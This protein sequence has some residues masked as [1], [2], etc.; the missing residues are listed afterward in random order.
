MASD[1]TSEKGQKLS[2]A[3][4]KSLAAMSPRQR[5][6]YFTLV[7]IKAFSGFLDI[8]G[9]VLIGLLAG[10]AAN[11]LDPSKPLVIFGIELPAV[12]QETLVALVLIV[13][14]VFVFKAVVAIAFGKAITVFAARVESQMAARIAG[15]LFSG[16]LSNLQR[17]SKGEVVWAVMGST[18]FAFGGL[19][20][21]LSIFVSEGLLLILVLA[22]FFLVDPLATLFVIVYFAII[23]AIIQIA[24]SRALRKSGID[25]A[26]GNM[27]SL[28]VVDDTVG[29]YREITVFNRQSFFV[30]K[31]YAVRYR[32]SASMGMMA[33]LGGMPRYIVETALM[34]GVVMF[35]GVQ[36][37][38]GQLASGLVIV[39]VFLT[40]GV[41]IMASLLP[42]Q[43]AASAAKSQAEQSMLAHQ[44]LGEISATSV[45]VTPDAVTPVA[46]K[47]PAPARKTTHRAAS[48]LS[49]ALKK[50][51]FRYPGSTTLALKKISL[52]IEPGQHVAFI[53]PSGAGK[54][55]LVDLILG[56]LEPTAGTVAIG[57]QLLAGRELL[58]ENLVAYVPQSPGMVSGTIA[59]NVAIGTPLDEI[60]IERVIEALRSAHL[61]EF[62]D[63][64]PEGIFTPVGSQGNSLSGGQI[65]RLGLARALY[66]K[67]KLIILDEA[68]S[69][70]DASAE[71]F[72]SQSLKE[73]GKDVTVIVIAHRLS[74]VQHSDVVFVVD[75]GE[76]V[77]SGNFSHLRKTVPMVAEYVRLMSFGD[78]DSTTT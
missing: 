27:G 18:G 61:S 19:L 12:S 69:A 8:A 56:L 42:L 24:I 7:A 44:L 20:G 23:I 43:N 45:H 75:G 37:V 59:E 6:L 72:I 31:F 38:T 34:L 50:V 67:P 51:D 30:Q 40:G 4:R 5:F 63:S 60:D 66:V 68:T 11:N 14:A 29:A 65:Q 33:F 41:R 35:V 2:Q 71:A 52:T 28:V 17:F 10:L 77:A 25:A 54:T 74:T 78:E 70:L 55:T 3:I 76:I 49:V 73:L 15:H 58:L 22:T 26:E 48:G 39:G 13:L 62:V 47:K 53:G 1:A 16:S 46:V 21:N 36:F 57:S 32:L 9:I 64:L